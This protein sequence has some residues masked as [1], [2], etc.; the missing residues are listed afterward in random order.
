M[1][2]GKRGLVH[3]VWLRE[4]I[5]RLEKS[6]P[7]PGPGLR[8]SNNDVR[9]EKSQPTAPGPGY[10]HHSNNDVRLEKS[11]STPGP[12]TATVAKP[13]TMRALVLALA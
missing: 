8:H 12:G 6:Q 10:M 5:V 9:L 1:G 11:Q 2:A 4:T 7:T 3:V 13:Q